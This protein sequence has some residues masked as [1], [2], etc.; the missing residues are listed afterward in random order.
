MGG[1]RLLGVLVSGLGVGWVVQSQ[2]ER[3]KEVEE[4]ANGTQ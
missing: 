2:C 3:I 1:C 4:G